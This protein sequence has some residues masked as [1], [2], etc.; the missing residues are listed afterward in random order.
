M[1]QCSASNYLDAK[2]TVSVATMNE[3]GGRGTIEVRAIDAA[4]GGPLPEPA[5][6]VTGEV[7]VL[8]GPRASVA[9]PIE[10]KRTVPEGGPG[11]IPPSLLAFLVTVQFTDTEGNHMSETV[12]VR[13][14]QPRGWEI[15]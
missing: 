4:G 3:I 8:L 5:G 10:W 2:M 11:R 14:R 13:E 1:F 15:F 7:D 9:L 12:T 6:V